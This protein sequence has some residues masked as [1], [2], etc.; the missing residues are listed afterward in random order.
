[1]SDP[2]AKR[3][4]AVGEGRSSGFP[5]SPGRRRALARSL[6]PISSRT[7]TSPREAAGCAQGGRA[8]RLVWVSMAAGGGACAGREEQAGAASGR[9]TALADLPDEHIVRRP[10]A[11]HRNVNVPFSHPSGGRGQKDGRKVRSRDEAPLT[12][13]PAAPLWPAPLSPAP[14]HHV[15]TR[16][17]AFQRRRFKRVPSTSASSMCSR[18]ATRAPPLCHSG[19]RTDSRC[20]APD[21][22][23]DAAPDNRE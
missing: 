3:R 4:R 18:P 5:E 6:E 12:L 7:T 13:G 14:P 8:C 22:H 19:A 21:S 20:R 11:P 2:G 1:M 9:C 17:C 16:R 23:E 15:V 10:G